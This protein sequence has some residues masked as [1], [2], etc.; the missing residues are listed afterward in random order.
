M[1]TVSIL[2]ANSLGRNFIPE[3]YLPNEK[4]EYYCRNIQ[5]P[6]SK[7]E[8]RKLRSDE[9]NRLIKNNNTSSNW[10]KILV[11][12]QFDP[13]QISDSEFFGLIRIG[14]VRNIILEHHNL[15]LPVGITNCI[16]S[17][18]VGAISLIK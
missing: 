5:N 16:P 12:N 4:D 1:D 7:T 9:V 6:K 13:G 14:S 18:Q 10:D 11:A 15:K 3:E 17:E 2:P 8:W